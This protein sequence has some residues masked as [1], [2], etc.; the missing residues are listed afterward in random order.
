MASEPTQASVTPT[1]FA[2][3]LCEQM[4]ARRERFQAALPAHVSLDRWLAT[5]KAHVMRE[6]GRLVYDDF[7]NRW[8]EPRTFWLALDAA[9]RSGLMLDG[10]EASFVRYGAAVQFMPGYQ[11]LIKLMK[12]SGE[13]RRVWADVVYT[14]DEYDVE[15]GTHPKLTHKPL[16]AGIRGDRVGAY[17]VVV[18]NDGQ[19]DFE[20]MRAEE[21]EAIK[22]KARGRDNPWNSPFEDEMWKKSTFRRIS[23]RYSLSSELD[24]IIRRDDVYVDVG[25]SPDPSGFEP[26]PEAP[27]HED[28]SQDPADAGPGTGNMAGH[29]P[30]AP[31]RR[32]TR[33]QT[34]MGTG[35]PT[36]EEIDENFVHGDDEQGPEP[37][38][39]RR[40]SRQG[41]PDYPPAPEAAGG[42]EDP[43]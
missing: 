5:A 39:P 16:L 31:A 36:Q 29:Q 22:A 10:K 17:C 35:A 21:I 20:W 14:N 26:S 7:K 1:D 40:P 27:A 33:A 25:P 13:V 12:Q 4:E 41:D 24:E 19:V 2:K 42:A 43:I 15:R 28:E 9:A 32:R 23:K 11:G 18:D 34:A 30:A 6:P 8:I 3:G 38:E 37:D